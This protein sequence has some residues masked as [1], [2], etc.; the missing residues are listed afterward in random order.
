[1][2]TRIDR[3]AW[4]HRLSP[5]PHALAIY[6]KFVPTRGVAPKRFEKCQCENNN[7]RFHCRIWVYDDGHY[8]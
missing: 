2:R 5:N 6:L 1:M 8:H 7:V 4:D 3:S